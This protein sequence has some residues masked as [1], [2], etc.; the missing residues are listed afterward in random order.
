MPSSDSVGSFDETG[1]SFGE[2]LHVNIS[3]ASTRFETIQRA[4]SRQTA[5]P[6]EEE[7]LAGEGFDLRSWLHGREKVEGPPFAKRFGLVFRDL[8]IYGTDVSNKHISTLITPFWKL[9]KGVRHGWGIPEMLTGMGSKRK[10]THG[11]SGEVKE[12]EMLLVLGRPGSGC[13][14]LLRVLGNRR[15]TYTKIDGKVSYGGLSPTE[16]QKHYRG[17]VVYNAEEDQHFPTLSVRKT[18]EFAIQCKTPSSQVLEDRAGYR[19]DVLDMLFDMYGLRGCADTIVGNATLRGVSGGER[20][21]VSIAEQVAAGAAIEVWDGSTRGLDS[22]SALDYVRSL[23]I[24]ADTLQKA[25][26]ASIYQASESIY[27][28]FDKV[29]VIDE[30]RQLYFGP[31]S[32][33]VAYFEALGIRKPSRQ[34]SSD[35]LTGLTQLNERHKVPGF[36]GHVPQTAEELE[37]AWLASSECASV[38]NHVEEFEAQIEH[39]GRS[40]EIREF[41]DRT[42][43]GTEQMRLRRKSPYTTTFAYQFVLLVRR[44]WEMQLGMPVVIGYQIVYNAVFSIILGTIFINL[45]KTTEGVF[46][47]GGALFTALLLSTLTSQ[48][49][50]PRAVE[51][52]LTVYKHKFLGLAHPAALSLAQSLLDVPLA[53]LNVTVFSLIF[54]FLTNLE[55][56]APHFFT[57]FLYILVASLALSAFFRFIGNIS[58]NIDVGHTISGLGLL[59]GILYSGYLQPYNQMHPWFIWIS[60][61]FPLPYAL[62]ALLANEFRSL[63]IRC[64][65]SSLIPGG[66]GFG[67]IANQVCALQGSHSG[68]LYVS[69]AEYLATGFG[70]YV[71]SQWRFFLALVGFLAFFVIATA[72]VMELVEFGNAGYTIRT[73]KSQPTV[74]EHI[75]Q[76]SAEEAKIHD[77]VPEEGPTDEQ[78]ASGTTYTWQ[79]VNYTVPVKGGSRQLLNNVSGFIKPGQMTALMGSSGA[80][81]TTLLDS[82]SQRK[83]IGTLQ[84]EMLM[85]GAPQPPSFRRITGYAE[86]QDVHAPL[87]TVREA[88]RFSAQLRQPATVP[89]A[90]KIA[91]VERVIY[92]LDMCDIADCLIGEPDSREGISLEER[93]RLTIGIE[94][95]SKPK[96]LFLDE[97]TS[98]LDAQASFKIVQILKRLTANGQTILCTIHQPSSLLFEA[99]DRL[100]LLVRG[101]K[102]VYFGDI[103]DDA[104]VLIS[105]FERNGA[106]KCPKSANPAEYILDVAGN[107]SSA[108][109]WPSTWTQSPEC[110]GVQLEIDRINEIKRHSS[111]DNEDIDQSNKEF[112]HG[113]MFQTQLVMRRM[114]LMQWRN[115]Q[116]NGTRVGLQIFSALIVGF[117][118]YQLDNS[119]SSLQN[120]VFATLESLVISVLVINQIQP[121]FFRQRALYGRESS[122]NQYGPLAF[123]VSVV[124]TEIPFIV[125]ANTCYFLIFYFVAGLNGKSNRA[126]YFYLIYIMLGIFATTLG[127]AVAAFAPND[128]VATLL[129]PIITTMLLLTAG[130]FVSRSQIPMFWRRWMYHINPLRYVMEGLLVNELHD[131]RI[132]CRPQEFYVFEPPASMSCREYAGAWIAKAPGYINNLDAVAGCQYC[133]YAIG[134]EYTNTLTWYY[135]HR[136]RN[137][138]IFLGFI[139]F[140]VVFVLFV[141]RIY[142]VNKR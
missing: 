90:E 122:T 26:V 71:N 120:R 12:G 48:S 51:G 104:S 108:V 102:T 132:V 32:D 87:V 88:L 116:Y 99:F 118:F 33:A 130:A 57:F 127:Q 80:G 13:S 19:K 79:G 105:Y 45:P 84:G 52:R 137:F 6:G 92:L 21:R 25:I 81:K 111:N 113:H 96:I 64:V 38:L 60:F 107:P 47:R 42:K 8:S 10:L 100:L 82:L 97:P 98:G 39:D 141:T 85:N 119:V 76:E 31:A 94:L 77:D 123:G 86:Q 70:I 114:F 29:M 128:L 55:R 17:E 3:R 20:K 4:H 36:T 124:F 74:V 69:G 89:L 41:V 106:P 27:K 49:Q 58:P 112:A 83:T 129:N 18:L 7:A 93:K 73:F 110:H 65:G 43:M 136:W 72:L 37:S 23:R 135:S 22:S 28:L 101:G 78:I 9:I 35:F 68:Q 5:S 1:M 139:V 24:N 34:T 15:K 44:E 14:T 95:V 63:R 67:N 131:S 121:Q 103:G 109:D 30:G 40:C 46:R 50:V 142:K 115:L 126:G 66:P 133:P 2:P 75:D 134:D 117:T 16:V 91:Y 140:N 56:T 61:I 125:V 54:Y 62:K 53:V 59:C 138:C 11:F